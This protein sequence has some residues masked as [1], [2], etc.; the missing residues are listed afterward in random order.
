MRHEFVHKSANTWSAS[1]RRSICNN[2]AGKTALSLSQHA[3]KSHK[4]ER[5][6]WRR[7]IFTTHPKLKFQLD[8][9]ACVRAC[10]RWDGGRPLA[11]SA[12]LWT[13]T[14]SLFASPTYRGEDSR[15]KRQTV[16]GH[17]TGFRRQPHYFPGL[18]SLTPNLP[19][20]RESECGERAPLE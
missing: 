7:L 8:A 5:Q 2:N 16:F 11:A 9:R 15:P 3:I 4:I 14:S 12:A 17:L 20:L 18:T 1:N 6:R 10:L 19:A 13:F